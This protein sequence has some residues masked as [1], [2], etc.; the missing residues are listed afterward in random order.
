MFNSDDILKAM[1]EGQ[2]PDNIA[3][4]FINALNEAKAAAEKEKTESQKKI[5]RNQDAWAIYESIIQFYETYY[6]DYHITAEEWVNNL[7][8]EDV[9]AITADIVS[10]LETSGKTY[11][12]INSAKDDSKMLTDFLTLFNL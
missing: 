10:I 12:S 9:S 4:S 2:S 5:R 8:A 1:K 11:K 6:P 3:N 7:P